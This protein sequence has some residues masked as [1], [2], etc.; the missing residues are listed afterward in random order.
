MP[1]LP[2]LPLIAS[3]VEAL[4]GL[5]S[6]IIGNK[7][8][9]KMWDMQN[10][11][12]S[13]KAQMERLRAAGLNPNLV[14]GSGTVANTS[15][16]SPQ[17][18]APEIGKHLS[19]GVLAYAQMK[20]NTLEMENMKAQNNVINAQADYL[21]SQ[22]SNNQS[23]ITYRDN[24]QTSNVNQATTNLQ[25]TNS[26]MGTEIEAIK[27]NTVATKLANEIKKK[28]LD[29]YDSDKQRQ[30]EFEKTRNAINEINKSY[31]PLEKKAELRKVYWQINDLKKSVDSKDVQIK[32]EKLRLT[33][34]EM[35][36]EVSD[37]YLYRIGAKAINF[38]HKGDGKSS[39]GGTIV[40]EIINL[41]YPE[42][43]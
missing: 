15:S 3:G 7:Q 1:I 20:K 17:Y 11:Y 29:Y 33:L 43:K 22:I 39:I 13:P 21:R 9:K 27:T 2:F 23:Q 35:G 12:N 38:D 37:D 14:Y 34:R 19:N 36:V 4:G 28:E 16:N 31:L 6:N 5:A 41:L 42:E 24:A 25:T 8:N 40:Q 10:E 26:K 30:I 32:L 18:N